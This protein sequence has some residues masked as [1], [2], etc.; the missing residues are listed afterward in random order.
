M[1]DILKKHVVA[2]DKIK[3]IEEFINIL[4]DKKQVYEDLKLKNKDKDVEKII[5]KIENN[6]ERIIS[7]MRKKK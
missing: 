3:Q 1:N 4:N 7:D 5:I 6:I 2:L